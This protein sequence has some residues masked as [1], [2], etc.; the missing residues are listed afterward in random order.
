[1]LDGGASR[2]RAIHRANF[3]APT[4]LHTTLCAAR[5]CAL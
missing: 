5:Q 4:A 1:M 2:S 3:A